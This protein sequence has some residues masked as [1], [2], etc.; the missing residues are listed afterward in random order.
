[1]SEY[2][3]IFL[4]WLMEKIAWRLYGKYDCESFELMKS[5]NGREFIVAWVE[6]G[7]D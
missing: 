5:D 4:L 1:M 6:K 7:D 2:R 3:K